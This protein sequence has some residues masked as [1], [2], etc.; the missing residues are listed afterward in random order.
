MKKSVL[1]DM[2]YA[3]I[4]A[5]Y[6]MLFCATVGYASV[7]LLN[8]GFNNSM[9]GIVLS[10]SNVFAVILQPLVA[11]YMDRTTK[12]TL[13][14][15]VSYAVIGM[16]VVSFLVYILA[17]V[18]IALLIF[19][20]ALFTSVITLMPFVNSLSF[21][22]EKRGY[23]INFGL[24]RGIGS[25]S[26][27]VTSL[28]LGNVLESYDASMLPIFYIVISVILWYS[29]FSFKVPKGVEVIEEEVVEEKKEQ[30]SLGQFFKKYSKF[31]F[32]LLGVVFVYFDH[33]MI[34][35][36]FIQIIENVGG[37]SSDMGNAVFL[38]ALVELPTM[39][40]FAKLCKKIDCGKLLIISGIFYSVKHVL[41]F[42][43]TSV[44]MIYIAQSIQILA[45]ALFIPASVYYV[46]KLV[47]RS[48][49]TKGQAMMTGAMTLSGVFASL[50]G[51]ILLDVVGAS[52]MLLIGA[53]LSV[54]G[55]IIMFFTTEKVEK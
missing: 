10:L 28:V 42:F 46:S 54:I 12:I 27:A 31:M 50:L 35:N 51:G 9:I 15:L 44:T 6:L 18:Q 40:I 49:L 19:V 30:L 23:D 53:I 17:G 21:A 38:A 26:Y 14:Q 29:V 13:S 39:A 4:Q 2:R 37:T 33:T 16:G 47:D 7:F 36:F 25:A 48:D 5:V 20:I 11:S 32:L 3:F 34:N 52:N 1:L 41:T 55:S 45:Y 43:A 8:S 22:F 24:A